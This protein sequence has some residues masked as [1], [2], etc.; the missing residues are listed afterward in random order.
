[1]CLS[2]VHHTSRDLQLKVE[3]NFTKLRENNRKLAGHVS[4]VGENPP[5][6]MQEI[7]GS[8]AGHRKATLN[9]LDAI[10]RD[11][12]EIVRLRAHELEEATQRREAAEQVTALLEEADQVLIDYATDL[13][14]N[15][16]VK[17]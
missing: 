7:E 6:D 2:H 15:L 5:A 10:H 8:F 16:E 3:K 14:A 12:L 1:M 17:K 11:T 9:L 4:H 13:L